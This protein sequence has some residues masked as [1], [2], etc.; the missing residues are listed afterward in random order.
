MGKR[1]CGKKRGA[2]VEN[3]LPTKDIRTLAADVVVDGSLGEGGGQVVRTST[4]LAAMLGRSL[5]V[6]NVRASRARPGLAAQHLAGLLGVARIGNAEVLGAFEGSTCYHF[7]PREQLGKGTAINSVSIPVVIDVRTAGACSLV[8]QAVLPVALCLLPSGHV[9]RLSGGTYGLAAPHADYVQ[10]VLTPNLRQFGLELS[11]VVDRH[12]FFP[13]GGGAVNVSLSKSS[14]RDR[15]DRDADSRMLTS[16]DL[17][18]QRAI[19]S[20]GGRITVAGKVTEQAGLEMLVI[21]E[22][23]LRKSLWSLCHYS[24]PID[25]SVQRVSSNEAVGN[26]GAITLWA[27]LAAGDE[28]ENCNEM[29][30]GASGLVQPSQES[31]PEVAARASDELYNILAS[32]A[33][34]DPHMADQ[35]PM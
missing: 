7:T 9:L 31:G 6:S 8:L 28:N 34:V 27:K 23:R 33:C 11:Y 30:L 21:A 35:L 22:K 10:H 17:I 16:I 18:V 5:R 20:V 19:S 26:C 3:S 14:I 13:K 24:G 12:G 4:A 2:D 15:L 32:G 29:V 1:K 25:I